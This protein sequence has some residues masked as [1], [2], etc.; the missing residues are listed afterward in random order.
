MQQANQQTKRTIHQA[1]YSL[2]KRLSEQMEPVSK[3]AANSDGTDQPHPMDTVI[4]LLRQAV[5]GIEQIRSRLENLESRLDEPAV[6]T[7]L[8][9]G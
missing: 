8:K 2:L 7:A 3:L 5:G 4:E 9:N 1:T 6:T